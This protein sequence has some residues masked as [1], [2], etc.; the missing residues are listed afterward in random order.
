MIQNKDIAV[1]EGDKESSILIM[2]KSDY[3]TKSD[4]MID[5]RILNGTIETTESILKKDYREYGRYKDMEPDRNHP[6]RL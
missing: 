1:V 4:T 3:L 2:K 5:D 6:A